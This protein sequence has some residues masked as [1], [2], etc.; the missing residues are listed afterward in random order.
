MRSCH[1]VG[2]RYA[3]GNRD[4]LFKAGLLDRVSCAAHISFVVGIL[5]ALQPSSAFAASSVTLAW[6]RSTST[7]IAGYKI[8]YG[9]TSRAYTNTVDTGSSTNVTVSGLVNSTTYYFAATAYDTSNLES[10]FSNEVSYTNVVL[11]PPAIALT[12]PANGAAFTAPASISLAASVTA[13]GHSIT[14]VRFYNGTTLLGE[15]TTAPY[16]F[17]WSSVAAGSYSLTG[18][19]VYDSGSTVASSAANVTVTNQLSPA[20]ALTS[21][22]NNA[23]FAAPASIGLAAS[24]T[25]NG[26]SIT[27]VQ[28]YNGTTL[29]G[30]DTTAPYAFTW[31]GV[32]AGSY[33][34]AARAVYDAGSTVA[35]TIANVTVTNQ[36]SPAIALTS[37]ANNAAFAAP[38]SI[39]LAASVTANG[40]SITRVQFYN[41]TTL[42]GE[43]TTAPYAFTWSG[44]AVGSYSL[45]ARLVYDGASTLAST[46]A[47]VTVTNQ[48]PPAIAL[49]SPANN[50]IFAAPATISLAASVT[51][52]GHS[53]TKVQFYNGATLLGEDTNAPYA[54]TWS[55][56]AVGTYSLS[57]QAVYDAGSTVASTA[58]NVTVSN[59]P[60]P[61]IALTS[62]ANNSTYTAPATISFAAGV[63][64]NGHSLTKVEFYSGITLL[65]EDTSAPYTLAWNNVPAGTYSLA[66]RLVYDAGAI[67]ATPVVNVLVAALRDSPP[68]ISAIADQTTIQDMAT[69][70]IS[71]TVWDMET[72][73]PNLTLSAASANPALVPTNN[74]VFGG[75]DSNRT[76]TLTP[77]ASA[78][79]T[80][81][82]T[83]FV[84][85][86]SLTTNTTF[87][88]AVQTPTSALTLLK[89]GN[90]TI[91]P[92]LSAQDL[93]PGRIY[94]VTAIPAEGEQFT[95]WTGGIS[96]P[97]PRLTFMLTSNLV[98]KAKFTHGKSALAAAG[99]GKAG[100]TYNGL[101]YE[102]DGVRLASAGSFTLRVTPNGKYSGRVQ[103][104]AKRYSFSGWLNSQ[105]TGATN[106]ISRRDGPALTLGF[107]IGGD[108]ADQISGHLTDGTWAST[109]SGDRAELST[110]YAGNYTLVIPGFDSSPSLPAGDSFGSLKVDTK[111]RV[112]F[113]GT[114]ADGTKASQS[115][116]LSKGGYWPLY[117]PLY[118]GS[119]SLM[120]WLAFASNTNSDLSGTLTWIKQAGAKSKYYLGG[121]TCQGDAFGSTYRPADPI[122]NL[123]TANLM[124][125][126][127]ALASDITNSI[128]IGSG[129]KVVTPDKKQLKLS[130]SKAT[131]TFKG[132][133]LDP[134]GGK[135]LPFSGTV[136]QKLNAAYGV[137]FGAGDQTSEVSLG[138]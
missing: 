98:L 92:D 22:A 78:T 46:A 75:S 119:G 126:G 85:D 62:P 83:I 129:N 84:S 3:M 1:R 4:M 53:I 112:K 107:Q 5:A 76:V 124:F 50:T 17:T 125:C 106:T 105:L 74:I 6:D 109:L 67:V 25:A 65:G 88:L 30:E 77:L 55:G 90:G 59:L 37:P 104:G 68:T 122:L 118:S 120:S 34:L 101:F 71:F 31:S 27:R 133:F 80:V 137:L 103:L 116:S 7:N 99:A 127:G 40:H 16:A 9:T 136:F 47:N 26:H 29:L 113:V 91:S 86:G 128:T 58:A 51:A 117:I 56:V 114:L 36:L 64:A 89:E 111:G 138:Q 18:Q 121:F 20:I 28:F 54:F 49:T 41:G 87:R 95:G 131:G 52:N 130:F 100:T 102:D 134:A 8:Y 15:D 108:Q 19:A 66:A 39:S 79:G 32:T 97:S 123:P 48:L 21:P 42:L 82:I 12:S 45:T 24:V 115:A 38:A 69:S 110:S 70:P 73:A 60:P 33:S 96:S 14:R 63:T 57:A 23:A 94:T 44:V 93:T 72:P 135:P 13:N 61:T 2:N 43:D 132:T 11:A 35:S 81:A 10:D